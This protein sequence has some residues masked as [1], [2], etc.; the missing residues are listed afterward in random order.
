MEDLTGTPTERAHRLAEIESEG[1]P[2]AEWLRRQ[3]AL[4]LE[5]WAAAETKIAVDAESRED[6]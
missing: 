6:Y 5:G 3:L 2:D 1:R 4:A